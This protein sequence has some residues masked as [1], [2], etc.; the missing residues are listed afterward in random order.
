MP[1]WTEFGKRLEFRIARHC[2]TAENAQ[3]FHII[4]MML[5]HLPCV[6][7]ELLELDS[8]HCQRLQI[9]GRQIA[10]RARREK[11]CLHLSYNFTCSKYFRLTGICFSDTGDSSSMKYHFTPMSL[12]ARKTAGKSIWPVPRVTSFVTSLWPVSSP[13]CVPFFM[14]LRCIN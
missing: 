2:K 4:V 5:G 6:A 7:V 10:E 8:E 1:L 9:V 3:R 13:V 12:A 14:S 11:S